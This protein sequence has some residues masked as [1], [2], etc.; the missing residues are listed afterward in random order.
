M[1]PE[2]S[3]PATG[4]NSFGI[5]SGPWSS[6]ALTPIG[7]SVLALSLLAAVRFN[8]WRACAAQRSDIAS[9]LLA[10]STNVR[11]TDAPRE[12]AQGSGSQTVSDRKK[13][14]KLRKKRGKDAAKEVLVKHGQSSKGATTSSLPKSGVAAHHQQSS[15]ASSSAYGLFVASSTDGERRAYAASAGSGSAAP[16]VLGD[17]PFSSSVSDTGEQGDSFDGLQSR[18][19]GAD[20]DDAFLTT[21]IAT[22][23]RRVVPRPA[24][25]L[26]ALRLPSI[27]PRPSKLTIRTLNAFADLAVLQS[28]SVDAPNPSP[29]RTI[30]SAEVDRSF[31][32][33]RPHYSS[34]SPAPSNATSSTTTNAISVFST[35]SSSASSQLSP[36]TPPVTLT[37]TNSRSLPV[38]GPISA[39]PVVEDDSREK[40]EYPPHDQHPEVNMHIAMGIHHEDPEAWIDGIEAPNSDSTHA[41][42]RATPHPDQPA[43]ERPRSRAGYRGGGLAR[44]VS[45]TGA[46]EVRNSARARGAYHVATSISAPI[47]T[48]ESA[49]D[50]SLDWRSTSEVSADGEHSHRTEVNVA[51][52]V[53][54]P[55]SSGGSSHL[56]FP[57][58][59]PLS[60]AWGQ[61]ESQASAN[62]AG[63]DGERV[64]SASNA[65]APGSFE[66]SDPTSSSMIASAHEPSMHDEADNADEQPPAT[67]DILFPSLDDPPPSPYSHQQYDNSYPSSSPGVI[68]LVDAGSEDSSSLEAALHAA[69]IREERWR[70]E[71]T[72]LVAEYE[73]LR[74]AWN[75]RETE[76]CL[77]CNLT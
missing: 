60:S 33:A 70:A 8:K 57:H 27:P 64:R 24:P 6:I 40:V 62:T 29:S 31:A 5:A 1:R 66:G 37:A 50:D 68:D 4:R 21:P 9:V 63:R 77:A 20:E 18:R 14:S 28:S 26:A 32:S 65:D 11:D 69:K 58:L 7:L 2:A 19:R 55:S 43:H 10:S 16:S 35:A 61:P 72:R 76:V 75:R 54:R 44:S 56:V 13:R 71:C 52:S 17:D 45:L 30:T 73:R 36:T 38:R 12:S 74:W 34:H 22:R 23:R 47:T 46:G 67:P 49:W 41:H 3:E 39:S 15:Y 51:E 25:A 53:I 59:L 48:G 42:R